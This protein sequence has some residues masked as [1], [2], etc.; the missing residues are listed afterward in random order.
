M[1]DKRIDGCYYTYMGVGTAR[2]GHF[3]CNED[4]SRV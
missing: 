3:I 4:N 1:L 2:S